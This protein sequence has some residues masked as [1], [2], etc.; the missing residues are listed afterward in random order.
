MFQKIYSADTPMKVGIFLCSSS[1]SNAEALIRYALSVP[2]DKRLWEPSLLLTDRPTSRCE[3]LGDDF[4]IPTLIRDVKADYEA[5]KGKDF[6]QRRDID[7]PY[8]T[9]LAEEGITVCAMAGWEWWTSDALTGPFYLVNM[10]PG[11]VTEKDEDGKPALMGLHH[12]PISKAILRELVYIHSS[13]MILNEGKDTG[14]GLIISDPLRLNLRGHTYEELK[15]DKELRHEI[16]GENQGY[17]KHCG[18]L[19][20]FGPTLDN[21]ANGNFEI[22]PEKTKVA[23][24]GIPTEGVFFGDM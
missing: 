4:E 23:Y 19:V 6:S 5:T 8:A 15:V 12:I 3:E 11:D 9:R 1:A 20:I 13:T 18:D 17:L 22:N 2:K 24:K 10:H 14:P 16:A 7:M 21:I